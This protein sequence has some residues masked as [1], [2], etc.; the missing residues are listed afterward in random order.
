MLSGRH[1]C[2]KR[3]LALSKQHELQTD[4]YKTFGEKNKGNVNVKFLCTI[5][6]H[7]G[8]SAKCSFR[9]GTGH[10]GSELKWMYRST[11]SLTSALDGRGC[12]T[13]NPSCFT[14]W[15]ETRY[16][17]YRKLDGASRTVWTGAENI[18]PTGIRS[19]NHP[20]RSQSLSRPTYIEVTIWRCSA[21]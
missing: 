15:K 8:Q 4:F 14:A 3:T 18:A 21:L 7:A 6:S 12:L 17:L 16:P 9:P 2:A 11:L 1:S 5:C 19:P 10:G 20:A 13:P